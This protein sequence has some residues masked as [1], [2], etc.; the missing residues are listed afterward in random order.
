MSR[1]PQRPEKRFAPA[2]KPMP[3]RQVRPPVPR[4]LPPKR[5]R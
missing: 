4:K 1:H 5:G 3:M 2:P